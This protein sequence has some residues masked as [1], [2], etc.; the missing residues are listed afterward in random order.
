MRTLL[1]LMLLILQGGIATGLAA[2]PARKPPVNNAVP[3]CDDSVASRKPPCHIDSDSVNVPPEMPNQGGVIVPP[4]VPA[5]GLPNRE[6]SRETPPE[7]P[8]DPL[9]DNTHDRHLKR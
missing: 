6:K 9:N 5:E 8:R 1:F 3:P 7:R 2:D 4:E